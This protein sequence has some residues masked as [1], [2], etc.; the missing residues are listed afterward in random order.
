L[1]P[2]FDHVGPL[3]R[4]VADAALLLL[5]I[6]GHDPGDSGPPTRPVLA[7]WGEGR[8]SRAS[9]REDYRAAVE[10]PVSHLRLGIVRRFFFADLAPEIAAS[11]ENAVGNLASI[12]AGVREI[13]IPIDT[14]RTVH[15]AEAWRYHRE[16]V[17]C[18]PELYEPETLKR[19][20]GGSGISQEDYAGAL[21]RIEELRLSALQVFDEVDV[22]VTPAVPVLPP[23]I[24]E[25][26]GDWDRLRARELIMLRNTRP[27][28]VLG[29]PA[30]SAPCGSTASGLPIGLQLA[31]AP[32][33]E[34]TLFALAGALEKNFASGQLFPLNHGDTESRRHT[35]KNS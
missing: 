25:L 4:S 8:A 13:E 15:N 30:L 29:W 9:D 33:R 32:G 19:I 27:F 10:Q 14:D 34:A 11:V 21:R 23:A 12:T 18:S 5:A 6:A 31:A 2:T 17:E 20:R 22:L 3:A 28:N 16:Y 24:A 7:C 1:A 35:E 26:T